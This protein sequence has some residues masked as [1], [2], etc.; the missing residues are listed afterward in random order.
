M[1]YAFDGDPLACISQLE[2]GVFL[3]PNGTQLHFCEFNNI[4]A[5]LDAGGALLKTNQAR[6]ANLMLAG[7]DLLA[8]LESAGGIEE[9]DCE[10]QSASP[11]F[12]GLADLLVMLGINHNLASQRT[13]LLVTAD[14]I[15]VLDRQQSKISRGVASIHVLMAAPLKQDCLRIGI[16]P[17]NRKYSDRRSIAGSDLKWETSEDGVAKGHIEVNVGDATAVQLLLSHT[18]TLFDRYWIIDL[19]KHTNPAYAAHQ[20]VDDNLDEL[21]RL[22]LLAGESN[23]PAQ[24]FE[25]GIAL[26]LG[27]FGFS[28]AHY[29]LIPTLREGADIHAFTPANQLAVIECTTGIPTAN[30]KLA[31]LLSRTELIRNALVKSGNAHIDILPIIATSCSRGS[32][33]V[34]N[35]ICVRWIGVLVRQYWR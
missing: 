9:I 33:Q 3:L 7:N 35:D 23:K 8:F 26:M 18:N 16:I 24:D 1:D 5:Q 21:K 22:L 14:A 13:G 2:K 15:L 10:L 29:G 12:D 30:D 17:V 34:L 32:E 4:S 27:L 20:T 6:S 28:T 31:K 11:P 19:E 25:R